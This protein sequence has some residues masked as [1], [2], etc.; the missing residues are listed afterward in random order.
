MLTTG[1]VEL[2]GAGVWW[3][4]IV[5]EAR[6]GGR[7]RRSRKKSLTTADWVVRTGRGETTA[8][9]CRNGEGGREG[10]EGECGVIL[11]VGLEIENGCAFCCCRSW[12]C[13]T[14]SWFGALNSSNQESGS[15]S[16]PWT[17]QFGQGCSGHA[18]QLSA[19]SLQLRSSIVIESKM[20]SR[21]RHLDVV[22]DVILNL[23]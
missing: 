9:S 20:C 8:A 5:A 6:V 3:P 18:T 19:D 2:P 17:Y 13:A 4:L 22:W 23:K 11:I 15:A 10:G 1:A 21:S 16:M 12:I 7:E 14:C